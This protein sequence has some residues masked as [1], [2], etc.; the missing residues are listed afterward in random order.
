MSVQRGEC[1]S[2]QP[3]AYI[4]AGGKS[5]R[6]RS[7]TADQVGSNGALNGPPME[8]SQRVTLSSDKARVEIAG[9]PQ[10][11]RLRKT[12]ADLGH[13]VQIVADQADRYVDLQLTSLQDWAADRGP[14]AGLAAA[15]DHR[16]QTQG[17]GW[18]LLVSVDQLIWRHEWTHLMSDASASQVNE[19]CRVVA[20]HQAARTIPL[21]ALYH[22][23]ALPTLLQLISYEEN[24]GLKHLLEQC[25]VAKV[26]SDEDPGEFA[27]N[28]VADLFRLLRQEVI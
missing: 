17:A 26:A 18:I 16:L 12:L 23:G 8:A 5:S 9:V 2:G 13:R 20:F 27:F 4:L 15:L 3:D 22:T 28:T 21:P 14:A 25:P 24:I 19:D 1:S 6:F 10:I 7:L 11:L